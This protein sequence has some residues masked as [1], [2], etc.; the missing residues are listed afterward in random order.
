[1]ADDAHNPVPEAA[2]TQQLEAAMELTRRI[3][4]ES[5]DAIYYLWD[6]K[7][8]CFWRDTDQRD[9]KKSKPV[10]AG[11]F[12]PT[13][14][15]RSLEALLDLI[16]RHPDWIDDDKRKAIIEKHVPRILSRSLAAVRSALDV[17]R[18]RRRNP[19]T[20]AL[21]LVTACRANEIRDASCP[22]KAADIEGAAQQLI[23]VCLD[24]NGT[25]ISEP[26]P[27]IQFH[28]LRAINTAL[29]LISESPSEASIRLLRKTI[30]GNIREETEKLLAKHMLN[31]LAP[32]DS[33]ALIFCAATLAFN[34]ATLPF[35]KV[36]DDL[37]Y[38]LPALT[39]GFEAQDSSGC[40]PLGRV[41]RR[42]R[43]TGNRQARDFDIST[44]EIAWAASET[45]LV[46]L[47]QRESIP[48]SKAL[49][50][51]ERLLLAG[52]Y[53]ERSSVELQCDDPP[54]RGWSSDS[55]YDESLIESWTSANVL[56]S[57]VSLNELIDEE[58]RREVL[59]TFASLDPHSEDWP[60]WKRWDKLEKD[61]EPDDE[62]PIY[63]YLEK[64]I[65]TPIRDDPR[66][67]PSH[68]EETVSVLFF[69]PPGTSKTTL[70]HALA[71]ALKWPIVMLSPGDFIERGLEY[72]EAQAYDVFDRLQK[73]R[74]V[75]VLFDECDELFRDRNTE[76]GTEQ[77]RTITAFVTASMLPKL[78][79]LHD[80]GRV[81][82]CIC[83]NKFKSLDPA[84]KRSG[85]I[86]HILGVPPP[87]R[88][89]RERIVA[90]R[91]S[92]IAMGPGKEVA[93]AELVNLTDGFVRREI[94]R[95]CEIVLVS[96]VNWNDGAKV[97][98]EV[99][100]AVTKIKRSLTIDPTEY[101]KFQG[102]KNEF[103]Q[104]VILK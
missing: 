17:P 28:V 45:L 65:V 33:V 61:A 74:R 19:F 93:I 1:M 73:L 53:A 21:Y 13:V 99:S 36:A 98:D 26:H 2:S 37:H 22:V 7:R 103:S 55:P 9:R 60:S 75:V 92:A 80:R 20:T 47:K 69:G 25:Y 86:D 102:L 10:D 91:L 52:R 4:V 95:A 100:K 14:T 54:K 40:W 12:F 68:K 96:R 82:F 79:E 64:R 77:N 76:P 15:Y 8:G 5:A 84:I 31:Q 23:N 18:S 42:F 78:Q 51:L 3:A 62:Y 34:A 89:Y 44:Y 6:D 87:Q 30:V 48:R 16:L 57:L 88:Q 46:L 11:E 35:N 70:A 71:D 94:Q 90:Q 81:L 58:I 41:V 39:V 104:A 29:P 32:S 101:E 24:K 67:L 59:K 50:A 56:Q 97:L 38:V 83:T 66:K 27:F 85:R 49:P 43:G 72:I 63:R